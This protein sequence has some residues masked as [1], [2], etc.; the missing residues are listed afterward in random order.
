MK[1]GV[2]TMEQALAAVPLLE[3]D[4]RRAFL[5]IAAEAQLNNA[6]EERG[7]GRRRISI[8]APAVRLEDTTGALLNVAEVAICDERRPQ[9]L[10]DGLA[11]M[12]YD[13]DGGGFGYVPQDAL[14]QHPV[15]ERERRGSRVEA[16]LV[17][18]KTQMCLL[19]F[20]VED[21]GPPGARPARRSR[22]T[23][24]VPSTTARGRR[25]PRSHE[26]P[27]TLSRTPPPT[28]RRLELARSAT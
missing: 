18:R 12:W 21:R 7:V 25:W 5:K 27:H 11:F 3:R 19:M 6:R 23:S 9:K 28:K 10:L 4:G 24:A 26:S 14:F 17:L 16:P 20:P 2:R 15:R 8:I 13:L 1:T 22:R